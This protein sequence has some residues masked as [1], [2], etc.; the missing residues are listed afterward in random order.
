M[1]QLNRVKTNSVL[2]KLRGKRT[3]I[4]IVQKLLLIK[5]LSL[6]LHLQTEPD[7]RHGKREGN[8]LKR[9]KVRS[10]LRTEVAGLSDRNNVCRLKKIDTGGSDDC[11]SDSSCPLTSACEHTIDFSARDLIQ[12]AGRHRQRTD[13]GRR[14]GRE[15]G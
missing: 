13:P 14:R 10:Q 3:K 15:G 4:I 9:M 12:L 6:S 5:P 11:L 2:I 7:T 1:S 8:E